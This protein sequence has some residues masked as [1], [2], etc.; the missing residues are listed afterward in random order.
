MIDTTKV[1]SNKPDTHPLELP[2]NYTESRIRTLEDKVNT[3]R[4]KDDIYYPNLIKSER[5]IGEIIGRLD[6]VSKSLANT[7]RKVDSAVTMVNDHESRIGVQFTAFDNR[8]ETITRK[9]VEMGSQFDQIV[10]YIRTEQEAEKDRQLIMQRGQRVVT[11]VGRVILLVLAGYGGLQSLD[12]FI[13]I[14]L[15]GN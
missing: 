7:T 8:I 13:K 11:I 15:G 12:Q 14:V 4:F 3:E 6:E 2:D 10:A 1:E 5:E 9:V